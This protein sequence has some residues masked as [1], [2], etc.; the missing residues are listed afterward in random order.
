MIRHRSQILSAVILVVSGILHLVWLDWPHSVV[1]AEVH[2]GKLI[3]SYCRTGMRFFVIH[4]PLMPSCSSPHPQN[5]AAVT[6]PFH[7]KRSAT[8]IR[9][10]LFMRYVS[11]TH[12]PG[13]C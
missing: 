8:T 1:F 2:F 3:N 7:S 10:S 9:T 13:P 6:A 5:W 11:S 4:P 12:W